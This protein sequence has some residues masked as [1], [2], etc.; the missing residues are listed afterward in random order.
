MKHATRTDIHRPSAFQTSDY[1]IVGYID[2]REE[3]HIW[4]EFKG[5]PEQA[6]A[7]I[8]ELRSQYK[9]WFGTEAAPTTCKHCGTTRCA[10]F[11]V[12]KHVPSGENVAIG[13][14][15]ST[16][17]GLPS[18]EHQ[19]NRLAARAEALATSR[20]RDALLAECEAKDPVLFA[21]LSLAL[22]AERGGFESI[23]AAKAAELG[24]TSDD[25]LH[26]LR[27][28]LFIVQT[29]GSKCRQ[30]DYQFA[31]DKQRE[32]F[33]SAARWD[34]AEGWAKETE[35]RVAQ[36]QNSEAARQAG[37]AARP[38]LDGRISLTGSFVSTKWVESNFGYQTTSTLKGLFVTSEGDKVWQSV[39]S[40]LSDT[41]AESNLPV[42]GTKFTQTI[43]IEASKDAG[44]YFGS[45]PTFKAI[46]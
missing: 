41:L 33:L 42:I 35:V 30:Y 25:A 15:C 26:V 44:F 13:H 14:Q 46:S 24:V 3:S 21:A 27:K 18:D 31:S 4:T 8:A 32:L 28:S 5:H 34:K 16:K 45:R 22:A 12:A 19:W 36:R 7:A 11:A 9:A 1:R 43:T 6:A 10:Y 20:K 38:A 17:I 40:K 39:P 37:I 29:I 23:I 2:V